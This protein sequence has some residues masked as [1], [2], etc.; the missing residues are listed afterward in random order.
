MDVIIFLCAPVQYS[1]NKNVLWAV[2]IDLKPRSTTNSLNYVWSGTI[3]SYVTYVKAILLKYA[4][5]PKAQ[6]EA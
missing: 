2:Q 3:L 5:T 4:E 6:S 1:I